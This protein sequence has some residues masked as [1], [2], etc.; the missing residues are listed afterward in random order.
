MS[1][2]H[3]S[4]ASA[5]GALKVRPVNAHAASKDEGHVALLAI[6]AI[7]VTNAAASQ[8]RMTNPPL[9]PLIGG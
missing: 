1:V 2:A 3:V 5:V 6:F 4:F 9:G 8:R 7:G